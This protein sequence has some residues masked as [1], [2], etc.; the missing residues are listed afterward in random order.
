MRSPM[1]AMAALA[2]MAMPT[3]AEPMPMV[4]SPLRRND[5]VDYQVRTGQAHPLQLHELARKNARR[6]K[7]R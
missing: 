4:S 3:S 1:L 7:R 2:M 6:K 5:V